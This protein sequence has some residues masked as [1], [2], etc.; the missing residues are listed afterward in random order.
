MTPWTWF[1]GNLDDDVYDLAEADTREKVITAALDAP[2][3]WLKPGDPFCI[4]EA[5]S[6]T[7]KKYEGSDFVPFLRTQNAEIIYL[8]G[9]AS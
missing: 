9:G 7:A 2:T 8:E 4:V 1:A 5:R 6:S 3:G